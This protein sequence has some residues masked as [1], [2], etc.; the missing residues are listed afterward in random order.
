[1]KTSILIRPLLRIYK[2][3]L[4]CRLA[5]VENIQ[6]L[7]IGLIALPWRD[8]AGFETIGGW[9]GGKIEDGGSVTRRVPPSEP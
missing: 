2:K 1:M 8:G 7:S 6:A 9:A 4:T 5:Q 3:K